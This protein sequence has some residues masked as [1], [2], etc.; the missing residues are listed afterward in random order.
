MGSKPP[1]NQQPVITLVVSGLSDFVITAGGCLTTAMVA[2]G[3]A[4]MPTAPV[5]VFAIVTGLIAT[6]RGLRALL[7]PPPAKSEGP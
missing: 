5:W 4:T 6:A 2:T 3:S 1:L 7:A